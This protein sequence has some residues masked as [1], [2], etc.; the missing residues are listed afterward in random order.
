[1]VIPNTM[2]LSPKTTLSG[3][4]AIGAVQATVT[5]AAVFP[6]AP[7][8]AIITG[9]DNPDFSS[10][11]VS[12]YEV[13]EVGEV[14]GNT[15]KQ[16]TRGVEG[17]AKAWPAGSWIM[18][19]AVSELFKRIKEEID[20]HKADYAT[21]ADLGHV[22]HGIYETTLNTTWTGSEAPFSKAQTVTGI[23]ATDNPIIDV[24]MS[25]TFATDEARQEAWGY[26]YRA[27]TAANK[28]TFYA[29]EKPEVS[30][31]LQIKVVR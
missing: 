31:P 10:W 9:E 14:S 30:L 7:F 5:S 21:L 3:S 15:I 11:E 27:V 6:A 28:I 2:P 18:C 17:T 24:V 20:T 12:D 26:I 23:L 1:M 13:I 16:I 8:L 25:G 22:K 4:M 19:G 29:M